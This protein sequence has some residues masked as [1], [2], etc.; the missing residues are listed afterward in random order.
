MHDLL[1]PLTIMLS[2]RALEAAGHG[3]GLGGLFFLLCLALSGGTAWSSIRSMHGM[4]SR[5]VHR[6]GMGMQAAVYTGAFFT[7]GASYLG[8]AGYA[9]NE[10]YFRWY[11]NLGASF[12]LLLLAAILFLFAPRIVRPLIG[13]MGATAAL[14]LMYIFAHSIGIYETEDLSA[15]L[16]H[17]WPSITEIGICLYT[18]GFALLGADLLCDSRRSGQAGFLLLLGT[19]LVGSF[20]WACLTVISPEKLSETTIPHV[21]LGRKV[22]GQTGRY[23]MGGVILCASFGG[24]LLLA[25]KSAQALCAIFRK[26]N[27]HHSGTIKAFTI[28]L[29]LTL[30]FLLAMGFAGEPML[31]TAI[32]AVVCMWFSTYALFDTAKIF[33]Q[34]T[35]GKNIILPSI[36]ACTHVG[37]AALTW[38]YNQDTGFLWL[39]AGQLCAGVTAAAF[40]KKET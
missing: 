5:E 31:E 19:I 36:S 14:L 23:L 11:P 35:S 16:N 25:S 39:L 10:I 6:L 1:L 22:L 27:P 34:R 21:I 38:W 7:L 8:L 26:K 4:M 18:A 3:T 17:L 13:A 40:I 32:S 29:C 15:A 28:I 20:S 24:T 30:A 2:P 37:M 9:V 33:S 12:S